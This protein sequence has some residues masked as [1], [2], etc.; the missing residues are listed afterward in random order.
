MILSTHSDPLL[1]E[2]SETVRNR[3]NEAFDTEM[4]LL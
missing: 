1:D 2:F 4:K 3:S